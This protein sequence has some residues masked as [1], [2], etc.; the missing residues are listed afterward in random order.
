MLQM[1]HLSPPPSPPMHRPVMQRSPFSAGLQ[2]GLNTRG[3]YLLILKLCL[4]SET[5]YI[6][7]ISILTSE[8]DNIYS[9]PNRFVNSLQPVALYECSILATA[10]LF[11]ISTRPPTIASITTRA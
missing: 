8:I 11:P 4:T 3:N 10:I 9:Q 2:P 5:Y 7:P 6:M 1:A